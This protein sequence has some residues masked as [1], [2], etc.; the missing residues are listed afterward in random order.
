MG[1]ARVQVRGVE[2]AVLVVTGYQHQLQFRK[3]NH[4]W[5]EFAILPITIV[6]PAVVASKPP[7]AAPCTTADTAPSARAWGPVRWVGVQ[8]KCY[9]FPAV[10]ANWSCCQSHCSSLGA[11]LAGINSKQDTVF[12]LHYKGF[13]DHW[14]SLRRTQARPGNG[15]VALNSS[16]EPSDSLPGPFILFGQE[17]F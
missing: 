6:T 1:T 17:P 14:I 4:T 8:D 5:N 12:T 11:S 3:H 2:Q 7:S 13:P 15:P 16:P 10:Q 9:R